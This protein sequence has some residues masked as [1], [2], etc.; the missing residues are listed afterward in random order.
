MRA[1]TMRTNSWRV[2]LLGGV[3]FIAGCGGPAGNAIAQTA[4][5]VVS[6]TRPQ[7]R[8]P[9]VERQARSESFAQW[10]SEFRTRALAQG[11]T[12]Q[13][14]DATMAGIE[15]SA[16]VEE[17]DGSQPEFVR[18]IWEYLDT[19]VSDTRVANGQ[20]EAAAQAQSLR[21]IEA[22][23][24]TD[25]R[26]VLAIWGMETAYGEV[27]GSFPVAKSL[28]TLA[29]EG[30]RR[31]WAEREL[32]ATMRIVQEG[33]AQPSELIGSWAGAMGHTQFM[34][35]S[36]QSYAQDF[37]GDGRRNIWANDPT[38]ALASASHYL[39]Q[40]G[41]TPGQ[42]WGME[43]RLPAGFDW[44]LVGPSIRRPA[45]FWNDAG[46]RTYG[47]SALPDHGAAALLAPAGAG[48]PVFL[49]Y[50]NFN[51]IKRYNNSDSYALAI[52]LLGDRIN[53]GNG[54]RAEWPRD[55]LPLTR[56]DRRE[57]QQRLTTLG[58]DTQGTDGLI[59]PNSQA[60]IRRFQSSQ[61]LVPDGYA[62]DKLLAQLRAAS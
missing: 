25:T 12:G 21:A 10:R 24:G 43:V 50:P 34:P 9:L 35:T 48:G 47:G 45:V 22:R 2:A 15:P 32:V 20:R 61:G 5:E 16:R 53:G 56:S 62:S 46:V 14:F 29:F 54:V 51:V 19:A 38:D 8:E 49:T 3:A 60:A 28:A 42:P 23:Y 11:I 13:V 6:T 58:Y 37:D 1:N 44:S 17:L 57:L 40:E 41:W 31:E 27:R 39:R 36:F 26:A 30:R 4:G 55:V 18:P 52:G 33:D 59:G 7:P